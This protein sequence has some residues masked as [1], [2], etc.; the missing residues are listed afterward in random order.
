[1]FTKKNAIRL[2]CLLYLLPLKGQWKNLSRYEKTW[3]FF[4]PFASVKIKMIARHCYAIYQS[5]SLK[6][7]LD[8]FPDGG[9]RDAFR[10]CFFMAAFSQKV[11]IKALRQLGKAHEK[12][13]YQQ[14]LKKRLEDGEIPDSIGSV[15]DLFNNE[16]GFT[17]GKANKT[18]SLNTLAEVCIKALS[19][20]KGRMLKR[21]EKGLYLNEAGISLTPFEYSGKWQ[22]NKCLIPTRIVQK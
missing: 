10:H 18:A 8:S 4:H 1:M 6:F 2:V 11:R 19:E 3:A 14:F 22:N 20:G 9:N 15:M 5:D 21:D 7:S 12:G 13:N 17:I 16:L